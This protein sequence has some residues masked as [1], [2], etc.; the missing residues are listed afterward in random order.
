MTSP[1]PCDWSDPGVNPFTGNRAAAVM[2][3][4]DIPAPIRQVLA[5]R[6]AAR[7]YD[8]VATLSA[9]GISSPAGTYSGLR[10]MYFGT[11]RR[12]DV[13]TRSTWPFDRVE[14]ALR[15]TEAGY[16]V[17]VFTVC[18]NVS[19]ADLV[20]GGVLPVLADPTTGLPTGASPARAARH[21]VPEPSSLG[22]IALA[23]IAAAWAR[24]VAP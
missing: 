13:V 1:T 23:L 14:R 12:C 18:G 21:S 20:P 17:L 3:Y 11:N 19:R 16:T 24:K 6:V 9:A 15:Y 22:L 7:Q 10:S 8:D 4:A 2:Q 5:A